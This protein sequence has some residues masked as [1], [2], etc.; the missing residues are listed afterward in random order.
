[1][2]TRAVLV[3]VGAAFVGLVACSGPEPD[4]RTQVQPPPFVTFPPASDA[5]SARCGT[6]DCH[7]QVARNLRLYSLNGLRLKQPDIPGEGATTEDEYWANYVAVT[8]LEPEILASVFAAAGADPDRLTL[9][10]KGRG[11]E[12]HKGGSAMTEGDVADLCIVAWLSGGLDEASCTQAAEYFPP[13]FGMEEDPG[14]PPDDGTLPPV[15]GP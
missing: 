9:I 8:V 15:T 7:G 5:L 11:T 12:H 1:M 3:A 10:R 4:T 13:D 6:L 2:M 14:L